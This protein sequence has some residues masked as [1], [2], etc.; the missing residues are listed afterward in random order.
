[1]TSTTTTG[2]T[3]EAVV[4][5][6]TRPEGSRWALDIPVPGA[7][8]QATGL[9]DG[10]DVWR[11]LVDTA[12]GSE[13]DDNCWPEGEGEIVADGVAVQPWSVVVW[14]RSPSPQP[15]AAR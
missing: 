4:H 8:G 9:A 3:Y 1:M 12:V 15:G 7:V 13:K 11:R 2:R 5:R 6:E 14:H 10:G